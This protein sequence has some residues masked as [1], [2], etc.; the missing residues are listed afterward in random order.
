MGIVYTKK[1]A[2]RALSFHASRVPQGVRYALAFRG[3]FHYRVRAKAVMDKIISLGTLLAGN[4]D[5]AR[6]SMSKFAEQPVDRVWKTED[7]D[8]YSTKATT[9]AKPS[10]TVSG[11]GTFAGKTM[12]HLT[13]RPSEKPG[14]WIRRTDLEEQL[15]VGVS[16]RNI[17]TTQRNIVLRSGSPHNYLRMVEHIIALRRGMGVDNL[18]IE[19]DSGDP[20]LF[21]RSSMDL[22]EAIEAA[23]IREL[24]APAPVVTV[25][26]PVTIAG[27]RGDFITLLPAA[28]GDTRLFCD[29]A[30]DFASAIGRQ[31]IQFEVTPKSF[32]HGALARTNASR[33]QMV[34]T[35]TVGLLFADTRNLGY[36]QANILIHG[37][38]KYVN[39]P[40]FTDEAPG[41]SLEPAWHRATLDLLAAISLIDCGRFAGTVCSYRAG[42]TLDC[43]LITLL[44]LND[45]LVPHA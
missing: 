10:E 28:K 39:A 26:E 34:Y 3:E 33:A 21:E 40:R 22:V 2:S 42:H 13:F 25:R 31:R 11:P 8:A 15:M 19:T 7:G 1:N 43:R 9:L 4:A 41:K 20:P 44:Y 6:F 5:A 45:L 12:R 36:T 23:G 17:W 29:V 18:I 14:W 38:K 24:D 27:N 16:P 32:R 30:I 37:K 35:H